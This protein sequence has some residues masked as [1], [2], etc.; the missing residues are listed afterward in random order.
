MKTKKIWAMYFSPTGTTKKAVSALALGLSS[1][2]GAPVEQFDFTLPAARQGFPVTG[3]D[4]I[5]VFGVPT[6]AGRVP[7]VLLK[8]L[9][10]IKSDG[11]RAVAVVTFGNRNFD[12]SLIELVD[13]LE[14][15]GFKPFAACACSCE[16]SFS[17]V[18]GA[19]RPDSDDMS[20]LNEFAG[21]IASVCE[22]DP[23]K[24]TVDGVRE[25]YG[26]YY[27]PRDRSDNH[28]DIRKVTPLAGPQCTGC[29]IC[30]AVCPMGSIDPDT[31]RER[32]VMEMTGI[33]IKCGACF[34]KCPE[35]AVY[36]KDP[37]YLYHKH[38][39]EEMYR[40]RAENRF[41]I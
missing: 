8:Y 7:N 29:G 25:N 6:Y 20:E 1:R 35:S 40:R 27:S 10:S 37:G 21:R 38:E 26:G 36:F 23:K 22:D 32:H 17:Y 13:I 24:I 11:A 34:K 30:A 4:D 39:L 18:L 15:G 3:P 12:N 19:G 16:H 28:I 31:L 41:F 5:A 14:N 2:L 9:A 33:C